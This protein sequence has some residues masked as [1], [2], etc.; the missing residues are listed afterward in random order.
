MKEVQGPD[1]LCCLLSARCVLKILGCRAVTPSVWPKSSFPLSAGEEQTSWLRGA[2]L[3]K[4]L[5]VMTLSVTR[6][7]CVLVHRRQREAQ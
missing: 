7:G 2:V 5:N 1:V 6:Q 3:R 4:G